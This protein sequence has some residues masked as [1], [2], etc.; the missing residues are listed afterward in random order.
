[1]DELSQGRRCSCGRID[2]LYL[3]G[4]VHPELPVIIVSGKDVT[5]DPSSDTMA[6]R[7][8]QQNRRQHN[9]RNQENDRLEPNGRTCPYADP[10]CNET[11]CYKVNRN[12][13]ERNGA[14]NNAL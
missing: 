4:R 1:M 3:F 8:A 14:V 10:T 6:K 5:P 12:T 9:C 7:R 11:R 13:E 2:G